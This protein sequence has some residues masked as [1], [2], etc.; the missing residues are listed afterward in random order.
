[1]H[2]VFLAL[3]FTLLVAC[4]VS[5]DGVFVRVA[6]E[7]IPQNAQSLAV[8]IRLDGTPALDRPRIDLSTARPYTIGLR[9]QQPAHGQLTISIGALDAQG[10]ILASVDGVLIVSEQ[11][12]LLPLPLTLGPETDWNDTCHHDE[13][14]IVRVSP[15]E[16]STAGR[17]RQGKAV[18]LQVHGWGLVGGTEVTI[19][20]NPQDSVQIVSTQQLTVLTPHTVQT[21]G[22]AALM[23]AQGGQKASLANALTVFM[24]P[25]AATVTALPLSPPFVAIQDVAVGEFGGDKR[26]DLAVLGSDGN[27]YRYDNPAG[28]GTWP[29]K[30]KV[31]LGLPASATAYRGAIVPADLNQDGA[32]DL[33]VVTPVGG[34]LVLN[35]GA[36]QLQ[37]TTRLDLRGEDV[38]VGDLNGDGLPDVV[39]VG[40]QLAVHLGAAGGAISTTPAQTLAERGDSVRIADLTH[41]GQLTVITAAAGGDLVLWRATGGSL[42]AAQRIPLLAG[43]SYLRPSLLIADLNR[44]GTLDLAVNGSSGMLLSHNGELRPSYIEGVSPCIG[45]SMMFALDAN[46]DTAIDIGWLL[47][48]NLT[49]LPSLGD[50]QYQGSFASFLAFPFATSKLADSGPKHTPALDV[51]G[52]GTPELL[53]GLASLRGSPQ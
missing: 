17:D 25:T 46:R 53:L 1:M 49:I 2:R 50:G 23:L 4:G 14:S 47:G 26:D 39:R 19:G 44:D 43:C 41:D 24:E 31:V 22:L 40:D 52:D 34:G 15:S 28:S 5:G 32:M 48:N 35:Q 7:K 33:V 9:L 38:A 45:G 11:D 20:P 37:A 13:L 27:V 8:D 29:A 18:A 42:T 6:V 10:C 30:A 3:A 16:I 12:A 36:G 51:D 21:P